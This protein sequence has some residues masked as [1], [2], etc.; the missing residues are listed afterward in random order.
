MCVVV[1][2]VVVVVATTTTTSNTITTTVMIVIIV[3]PC[4]QNVKRSIRRRDKE[5]FAFVV[6]M[7]IMIVM[8]KFGRLEVLGVSSNG[9]LSKDAIQR[10]LFG[11]KVHC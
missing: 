9:G 1:V 7:I 11:K 6:L 4:I 8:M 3:I 2:V 10:L 5:I